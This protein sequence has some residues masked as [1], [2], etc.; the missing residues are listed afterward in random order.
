MVREGGREGG[1][2]VCIWSENDTLSFSFVAFFI[3]PF[4]KMML[5]KPITLDDMQSV[6]SIYSETSDSGPSEKGTQY[7]RPL[8]KGHCSRSPKNCLP[9][10]FNTLYS[11]LREEDTLSTKDKTTVNLYYPQCVPCSEVPLYTKYV[12]D[13]LMCSYN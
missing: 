8:Y 11:N 1:R 3:R 4:Y 13:R 5:N 2:E 12:Y 10:S 6:V 9:Y 7:K